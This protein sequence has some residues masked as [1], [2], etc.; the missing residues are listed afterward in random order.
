MVHRAGH[1]PWWFDRRRF[2][3][4]RNISAMSRTLEDARGPKPEATFDAGVP[5][6]HAVICRHHGQVFLTAE[7]YGRQMARPDSQWTCPAMDSSPDRFGPCGAPSR[8]DDANSEAH[9]EQ[10]PL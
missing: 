10:A 3:E 2:V 7:E 4:P 9:D 1:R 5:G 6:P 8:W